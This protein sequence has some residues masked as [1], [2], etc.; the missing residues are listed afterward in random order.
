MNIIHNPLTYH[1]DPQ[2]K[3]IEAYNSVDDFLNSLQQQES[4]QECILESIQGSIL[5]S[6]HK[7]HL[8]KNQTP[9][10]QT[11][12]KIKITFKKNSM[13]GYAFKILSKKNDLH[14]RK[15]WEEMKILG[16]ISLGK[17]PWE[18]LGAQLRTKPQIFKPIGKGI[19]RLI[20]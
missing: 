6:I 9:I 12:S 19:Y 17:T 13:L 2:V 7:S 14:F 3:T 5:K 8:F 20:I 15:I 18:T 11:T 16:Y 10:Y 4:I 1:P